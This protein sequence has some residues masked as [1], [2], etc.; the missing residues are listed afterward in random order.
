MNT[1]QPTTGRTR[2]AAKATTQNSRGRAKRRTD[3][4]SLRD[5]V[6]ESI[7]EHQRGLVLA[8]ALQELGPSGR[9][10]LYQRLP[11]KLA[12][13]LA[14]LFEETVSDASEM[15]TEVSAKQASA[16]LENFRAEWRRLWTAWDDLIAGT[17]DSESGYLRNEISYTSPDLDHESVSRDLDELARQLK[18]L[19]ILALEE[20]LVPEF[21]LAQKLIESLQAIAEEVA[22]YVI[23]SEDGTHL[24]PEVTVM[25]LEWLWRENQKHKRDVGTFAK[26]VRKLREELGSGGFGA[27]LDDKCVESFVR[28]L[29]PLDR[30]RIEEEGLEPRFDQAL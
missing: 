25:A 21:D 8:K 7:P 19:V 12:R 5:R 18:P 23:T 22:S 4:I 17:S 28:A 11:G 20:D 29:R 27:V 3:A 10:G 9:R 2:L 15:D 13:N 1:K 30:K 6:R 24:G 14:A 26:A 16:S